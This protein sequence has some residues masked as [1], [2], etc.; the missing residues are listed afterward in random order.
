MFRRDGIQAGSD[1]AILITDG[2]KHVLKW[3]KASGLLFVLQLDQLCVKV[4]FNG[5]RFVER[6]V[7]AV[8]FNQPLGDVC[9]VF[10]VAVTVTG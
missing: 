5:S 2:V 6:Q 4:G 1:P 10:V 3:Q 8:F 9:Y 7:R